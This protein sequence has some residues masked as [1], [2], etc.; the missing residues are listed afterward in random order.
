MNREQS[1]SND[2]LSKL[3]PVQ[4]FNTLIK[5]FKLSPEATGFD[6]SRISFA[7]NDQNILQSGKIVFHTDSTRS[8]N[9]AIQLAATL[10]NK[11]LS[12]F[13]RNDTLLL[14]ASIS[15]SI[16]S[17]QIE[18]FKVHT[19]LGPDIFLSGSII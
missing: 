7:L 1:D 5:D 14:S 18:K 16:D 3:L 2:V 10:N 17:L 4:K 8:V 9:L 11:Q 15:G 6:I 19:P 13:S 12:G